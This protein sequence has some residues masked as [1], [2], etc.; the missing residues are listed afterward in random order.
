MLN[1]PISKI[2]GPEPKPLITCRSDETIE[3]ALKICHKNKI[4]S[5]PVVNYEDEIFARVSIS[6]ILFYLF[7]GKL[8][9]NINRPVSKVIKGIAKKRPENLESGTNVLKIPYNLA[10]VMTVDALLGPFSSGIHH[11]LVGI[12]PGP[13]DEPRWCNI[14]QKDVIKFLYDHPYIVK[15]D[16]LGA[17]VARSECIQHNVNTVLGS[18]SMVSAIIQLLSNKISALA[19]L[20]DIDEVT[21]VGTLSLSDLRSIT[22]DHLQDMRQDTVIEYL[23]KHHH[24][25]LRKP[26]CVT[27]NDTVQETIR[28]M[29]LQNVHRIWVRP[30]VAFHQEKFNYEER[31]F[32]QE[33]PEEREVMLDE[34]YVQVK[35]MGVITMTD[36]FKAIVRSRP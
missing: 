27:P 31:I 24:G 16:V 15:N 10:K 13:F 25:K 20:D 8:S 36:L 23:T 19:V 14:S 12:E 18:S 7:S 6:D 29:I 34:Y 1:C 3:N 17:T 5:L 35:P 11:I 2:I 9:T 28:R 30:L 22:S 21:L 4:S 33:Q 32:Q 26:F